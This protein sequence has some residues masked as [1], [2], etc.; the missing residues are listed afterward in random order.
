MHTNNRRGS[1]KPERCSDIAPNLIVE[2]NMLCYWPDGSVDNKLKDELA[3]AKWGVFTA[4]NP[5]MASTLA[6]GH[7]I[8]V[9]IVSIG[10]DMSG[11][12]L[13][14]IYNV[15]TSAGHVFWHIVWIGLLR[16]RQRMN[17]HVCALV[18]DYCYDFFTPP[19]DTKRILD[20]LGHADGMSRILHRCMGQRKF[21]T[22]FQGMVGESPRMHT[23]FRQINKVAK[24]DAPVLLTGES[25]TGK[26]LT[27]RAIHRLSRRSNGPFIAV[28]C[29]ALP[30]SLI[31]SELFGHEKGAFTGAS[32]RHIGRLESAVGGTIFLDE[33]SDMP[34]EL[35]VNLLRFLE[36]KVIERLGGNGHTNVDARVICATHDN[37][38]LAAHRGDFREDL[39]YRL[40]VLQLELPSLRERVADIEL[41]ANFVVEKFAE[42]SGSRIKGFAKHALQAMTAYPWPGNVRELINRVRRAM[43]M[44]EGRFISPGDLGLDVA[45]EIL[46]PQAKL[47]VV[48]AEAERRAIETALLLSHNNLSHAAREL[49]ISRTTLYR[50]MDKFSIHT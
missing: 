36:E 15:V 16:D 12:S 43:V 11:E 8:H 27:A 32:Q 21:T 39:Y 4:D 28:N 2:R 18:A 40:N 45:D 24:S 31:Q 30:A 50:M 33:I 34:L 10:S 26:E 9:G 38:D 29:A 3:A 44:S 47:E 19:Y 48:R 25:G 35:Q 37:L 49:G 1:W 13:N 14:D 22:A 7:T 20:T 17:D 5:A 41:L 42:E 46:R 6:G 23:L